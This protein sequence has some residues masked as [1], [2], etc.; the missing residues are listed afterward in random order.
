[1]ALMDFTVRTEPDPPR[2][3]VQADA[4][5][6]TNLTLKVVH[7]DL[8]AI[9]LLPTNEGALAAWLPATGLAN[10]ATSALRRSFENRT[11]E[12]PLGQLLGASFPA[13]DTE[14][15]VRLDRPELGSHQ[16]MLMISGTASVS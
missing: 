8:S 12:V 1:M 13:G 15:R 10:L 4:L 5:S 9:R 16:G 2:V 7:L 11:F 6:D 14:V 3:T